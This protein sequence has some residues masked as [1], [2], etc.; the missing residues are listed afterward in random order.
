MDLLIVCPL[1]L[2]D[3]QMRLIAREWVRRALLMFRVRHALD[4]I[5]C[6]QIIN[7]RE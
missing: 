7:D 3:D 1:G 5:P 4:G 6:E 2:G